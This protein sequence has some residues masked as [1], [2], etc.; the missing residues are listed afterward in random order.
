MLGRGLSRIPGPL[1]HLRRQRAATAVAA[2][3]SEE[4]CL[5][6]SAQR[7]PDLHQDLR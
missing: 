2:L 5:D 3:T 1:H 6:L 7:H 4:G